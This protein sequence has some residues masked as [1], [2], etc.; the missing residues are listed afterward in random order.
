VKTRVVNK[1]TE[2]FDVYIGRGS[3]WGNPYSWKPGTKAKYMVSSREEAIQKYKEWVLQQP[4]LMNSLHELKGKTLGC[5]C[6]PAPCHGDVLV[7]L[8]EKYVK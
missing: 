6:K 2:P 3:K 1:Y 4:T 7:E 5:F 8:V